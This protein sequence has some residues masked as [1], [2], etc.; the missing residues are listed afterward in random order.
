MDAGSAEAPTPSTIAGRLGDGCQV[1]GDGPRRVTLFFFFFFSLV[2][3]TLFAVVL[4]KII[5]GTHDELANV[6]LYDLI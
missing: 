4:W 3:V 2:L 6:I 1:K 5:K